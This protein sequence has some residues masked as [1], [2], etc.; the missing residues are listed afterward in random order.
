MSA[1]ATISE[2]TIGWVNITD[3]SPVLSGS[4]IGY[5]NASAEALTV[6]GSTIGYV[7]AGV[8]A[9]TVV[10]STFTSDRPLRLTDP[11]VDTSGMSGNSYTS[12]DPAVELRGTLDGV[13]TLEV[14]DGVLGKYIL[15]SSLT[16]ASGATLSL[17][18]GVTVRSESSADILVEGRLEGTGA[19][20][21]LL[22]SYYSSYSHSWSYST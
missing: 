3:G 6:V 2:S 21:E 10:G 15:T 19:A 8:E 7:Q 13:R 4:T 14:I 16:V 20:I 22:Y 11:D 18:P 17:V 12:A 9:L 5:V 1:S